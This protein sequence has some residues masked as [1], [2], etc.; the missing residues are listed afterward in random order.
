MHDLEFT[1]PFHRTRAYPW[2]RMAYLAG[3]ARPENLG[4]DF[5]RAGSWAADPAAGFR[6]PR[7]H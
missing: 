6:Y 7:R 1:H 4:E 3:S 2:R 5:R